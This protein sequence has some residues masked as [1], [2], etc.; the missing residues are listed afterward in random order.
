MDIGV[1][2]NVLIVFGTLFGIVYLIF[3]AR[4]RV[5]LALIEKGA[6]ASIFVSDGSRK[7]T[8]IFPLI[9]VNI[10]LLLAASG[11]GIFVGAIMSQSMGVNEGVAYPGS[12][13][14]LSGIALF[15]GYR[16][17]SNTLNSSN[18]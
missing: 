14:T 18:S 6:D 8:N 17:A 5:R 4:T 11:I 15:I 12:I 13:L 10:A 7:K 1:V 9:L 2:I 16:I 3:S